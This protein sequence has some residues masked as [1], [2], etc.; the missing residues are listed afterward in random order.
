[1]WKT[2]FGAL[3]STTHE[4]N[5]WYP[6]NIVFV[7]AKVFDALAPDARSAVLKAAADAEGRGWLASEA[8]AQ[9]AT[10]EL[11]ANGIR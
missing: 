11:Q 5:A 3:S 7:N 6:K 1:M 8:V 2:R 10:K 9:S 4:I